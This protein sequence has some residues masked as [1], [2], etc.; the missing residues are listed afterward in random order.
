LGNF[1]GRIEKSW[2][3]NVDFFKEH[4]RENMGI[5]EENIPLQDDYNLMRDT[6]W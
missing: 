5:S 1:H 6:L 2:R 4:P 3:W